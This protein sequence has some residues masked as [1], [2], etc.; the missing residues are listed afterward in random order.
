VDSGVVFIYFIATHNCCANFRTVGQCV[1]GMKASTDVELI[2]SC[3][4]S[5]K[6]WAV[7]TISLFKSL[8]ELRGPN[9]L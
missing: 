5:C 3:A 6:G 8:S 2:W 7:S 1:L 4:D 9:D